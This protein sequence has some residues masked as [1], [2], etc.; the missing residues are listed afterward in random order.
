M[1]FYFSGTGNT[2]WAATRI[3]QALGEELVSIAE[4]LDS[5]REISLLSGERVGFCFPIHG[6]RPPF[7]VRNF[8]RSLHIANPEGHYFY[9]FATC[10]DDL[11]LSMDYLRSDLQ[12]A[13]LP[14]HSVF[15]IIMPESYLFPLVEALDKPE[16][17]ERK[18]AEGRKSLAEL[19]PHIQNREEGLSILN[20]SRW[21]RINSRVLGHF[22][23]KH[24][25]TDRPFR[26]D[27]D[28]CA[29]CGKCADVCPVANIQGERG[30]LP[31][32]LH[33]GRC[34]TCF[35]CYHHCPKHAILFGHRTKGRRQYFFR[36]EEG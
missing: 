22:F 26:V 29:R 24:W 3:A 8:V 1:V 25:V 33:N 34:T 10:G 30:Q 13:G 23:L 27:A 31:Q 21:P 19:L 14:L 9:A 28:L 16:V 15:S 12:Q 18:K 36:G 17:A 32:W 11:G 7:L 6:W 5:D 35:S 20:G 2:R 4:A